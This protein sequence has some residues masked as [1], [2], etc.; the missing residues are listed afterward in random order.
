V[1]NLNINI[2]MTA[3]PALTVTGLRSALAWDA[4][5]ITGCEYV[6]WQRKLEQHAVEA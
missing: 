3:M 6:L 4:Y 5:V 1:P 2:H